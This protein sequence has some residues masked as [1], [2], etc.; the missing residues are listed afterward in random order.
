M[1]AITASTITSRAFLGA[2]NSAYQA[3]KGGAVDAN[4]SATQQVKE[5][6]EGVVE[7][8]SKAACCGNP[9]KCEDNF[10]TGDKEN[11]VCGSNE[12]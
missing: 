10:C 8:V 1:D 3:Y 2:V 5:A 9:E 11:C 12:E 6:V 7:T 4:S